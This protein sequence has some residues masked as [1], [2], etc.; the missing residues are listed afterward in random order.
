MNQPSFSRSLPKLMIC[1]LIAVGAALP[2]PGSV[3]SA[4]AGITSVAAAREDMLTGANV[5]ELIALRPDPPPSFVVAAVGDMECTTTDC[6]GVGTTNLVAN[7]HAKAFLPLGDLIFKGPYTNFAT[8]Y[9]P[10]WGAFRPSSRPEIGNHENLGGGYYDYWDGIGKTTGPVGTRGE[11]WYSFNLGGWHFVGLNS[12]CVFDSMKVSCQPGSPQINWLK[13]DLAADPSLCTIAFMHHPYYSTSATQYPELRTIFET[14]YQHHVELYL[15]GHTHYYQRFYPQDANGNRNNALG[16]TE[17]VAGTGGA[18][19]A[20]VRSLGASGNRARQIGKT[21]GVL[22]LTLHP[23]SYK[24]QFV[25]V[26][27]STET[28]SGIGTCH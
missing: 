27:G 21:F 9:D 18:P 16:V 13:A 20:N 14:L 15:A 19:L 12:N 5:T 17:I 22:K 11:G 8:F 7:M 25:P 2:G 6:Q 26:A 23:G 4:A 3:A 1:L 10:T 28:D 24:F